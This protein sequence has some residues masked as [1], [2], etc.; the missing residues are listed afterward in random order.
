MVG[1]CR[2]KHISKIDLC[3]P[4]VLHPFQKVW[5]EFQFP[6]PLQGPF[7]R[8]QRLSPRISFR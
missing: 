7:T 3:K 2:F 4:P 8:S 6:I 5:T 1:S